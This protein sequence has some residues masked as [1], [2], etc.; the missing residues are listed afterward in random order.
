MKITARPITRYHASMKPTWMR[1]RV[2]IVPAHY[3]KLAF[4][5]CYANRANQDAELW[6]DLGEMYLHG[7]GVE[8]N[9]DQGVFWHRKAAE[10]GYAE[11]QFQLGDMYRFGIAVEASRIN[12]IGELKSF[13]GNA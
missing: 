10:H 4:D 3:G 7:H 11:S 5:W 1:K 6:G 9:M 2:K 13:V 8:E 12:T